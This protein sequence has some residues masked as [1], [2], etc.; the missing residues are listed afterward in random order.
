[1][2]LSQLLTPLADLTLYITFQSA[3]GVNYSSNPFSS[4]HPNY[5]IFFNYFTFFTFQSF[6]L[7]TGLAMS[8]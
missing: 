8:C 1:M 5:P 3:K 7:L 2:G 6:S 4:T